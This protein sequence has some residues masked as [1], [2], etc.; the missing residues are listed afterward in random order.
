[1]RSRCGWTNSDV[2][3][4][5][6]HAGRYA[7]IASASAFQAL[8]P[9][10]RKSA[11]KRIAHNIQLWLFGGENVLYCVVFERIRWF[12]FCTL[13]CLWKLLYILKKI[14]KIGY[15]KT[16]GTHHQVGLK[17]RRYQAFEILWLTTNVIEIKKRWEYSTVAID[18]QENGNCIWSDKIRSY[19]RYENSRG[20]H[21]ELHCC[22]IQIPYYL[23]CC[24]AFRNR[25]GS[26][27]VL[28]L[29]IGWLSLKC[30]IW[31]ELVRAVYDCL[32]LLIV[33][34]WTLVETRFVWQCCNQFR[35]W[36]WWKVGYAKLTQPV[37]PT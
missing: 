32:T 6:S 16:W 33:S 29:R 31:M 19:E 13:E 10:L 5:V 18:S 12:D 17:V 22:C 21:F 28:I 26:A 20:M 1:M 11:W 7:G 14:T 4:S 36:K 25:I 9:I 27:S 23:P 35:A 24:C 37:G 34:I 3:R 2:I 15:G 30:V 8:Q